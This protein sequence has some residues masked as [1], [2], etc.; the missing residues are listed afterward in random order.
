MERKWERVFVYCVYIR[1]T[2]ISHHITHME[3][4]PPVAIL[5]HIHLPIVGFADFTLGLA[6]CCH[7]CRRCWGEAVASSGSVVLCCVVRWPIVQVSYGHKPLRARFARTQISIDVQRTI[8]LQYLHTFTTITW[9]IQTL[10]AF[11]KILVEL[12][13]AIKRCCII[14]GMLDEI[15]MYTNESY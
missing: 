6:C 14:F 8:G 9:T 15:Q 5:V 11:L 2:H 1:N 13:F 3:L 7:C 10:S 12:L 4:K